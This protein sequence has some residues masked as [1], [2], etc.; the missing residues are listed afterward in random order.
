MT[1][2]KLDLFF[3]A[4]GLLGHLL[5]LG[6]LFLRHHAKTFPLFTS[7]VASNIAQTAILYAVHRFGIATDYFRV[8]WSFA[9]FEVALQLG[10]FYEIAS[11]IFRPLGVWAPDVRRRLC[12]LVLGS[13][14]L[15]GVFAWLASPPTERVV[16]SVF[17][18]GNLFAAVLMSE[19][20]VVTASVSTRVG[21]PWKSH[22]L[23]LA[24]G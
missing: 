24:Q 5:L 11:I 2:M 14:T 9:I 21:L 23:Q 1:L 6:I 7:L 17:V 8:Y 19:L 22:V 13:F 12:L 15:A 16:Q 18:K 3:W 20:F 4:A 10:V